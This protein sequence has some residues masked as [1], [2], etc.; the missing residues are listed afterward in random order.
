MGPAG[1]GFNN[2]FGSICRAE[3]PVRRA[4]VAVYG[5]RSFSRGRREGPYERV[6]GHLLW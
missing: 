5:H 6:G 4:V 3:L 1:I 2:D